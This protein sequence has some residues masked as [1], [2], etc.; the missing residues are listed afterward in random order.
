MPKFRNILP[1]NLNQQNKLNRSFLSFFGKRYYTSWIDSLLRAKLLDN[2]KNY[3]EDNLPGK[4]MLIMISGGPASGKTTLAYNLVK[5]LNIDEPFVAGKRLQIN[6]HAERNKFKFGDPILVDSRGYKGFELQEIAKFGKEFGYTTVCINPWIDELVC[7]ERLQQRFEEINRQV[8]PIKA[9]E[10]HKRNNQ[11]M[12]SYMSKGN[13]PFDIFI[14]YDNRLDTD[15]PL[16]YAKIK[17][18]IFNFNPEWVESL[19]NP[20]LIGCGLITMFLD[21]TKER[22][23]RIEPLL[24][25]KDALI[26]YKNSLYYADYKESKV[27]HIEFSNVNQHIYLQLQSQFSPY[28]QSADEKTL[29]L[30]S[31]LIGYTPL[32]PYIKEVQVS[33]L[34]KREKV[35]TFNP[36]PELLL[37]NIQFILDCIV[38]STPDSMTQLN[39]H[40]HSLYHKEHS[41]DV[42]R[43]ND[44]SLF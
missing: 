1:L 32:I 34:P 37:P 14:S 35:L 12:Y 40:M 43:I 22:F 36:K 11:L 16:L 6:L 10:I 30:I 15:K 44:I 42:K 38:N 24:D 29:Q 21:P 26:L 39:K 9:W 17:E 33:E 31:E 25:T 28:Y 20:A 7:K 5:I 8:S 19:K 27:R 2:S 4:N 18:N 23:N 13:I 3:K 41:E